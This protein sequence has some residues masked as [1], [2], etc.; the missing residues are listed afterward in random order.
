MEGR[1]D[2]RGKDGRKGRMEEERKEGAGRKGGRMEGLRIVGPRITVGGAVVIRS[3]AVVRSWW[4]RSFVR[5]SFVMRAWFFVCPLIE[6][7]V[8]PAC[9]LKKGAGETDYTAHLMDGDDEMRRHLHCHRS[10]IRMVTLSFCRYVAPGLG[11]GNGKGR[12]DEITYL[13]N[14]DDD[15]RR[16]RL[17]D[18]ARLLTCSVIAIVRLRSLLMSRVVVVEGS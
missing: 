13:L 18:V 10:S 17:D 9:C 15:M 12:G 1:E 11:L 16:H 4:S 7:D 2:G 3:R 6:G 14:S 5:S 8:A